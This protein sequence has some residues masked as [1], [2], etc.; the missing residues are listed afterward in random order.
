M[1]SCE[2]KIDDFNFRELFTKIND[3]DKVL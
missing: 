1:N 3:I 2:F